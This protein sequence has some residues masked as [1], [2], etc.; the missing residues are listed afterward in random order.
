[1]K[2]T[3]YHLSP[4]GTVTVSGDNVL[5]ADGV[6]AVVVKSGNTDQVVFAA[7]IGKISRVESDHD[8]E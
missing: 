2:Y 4:S 3:I 8:A 5:F 6:L 7:P 1:M